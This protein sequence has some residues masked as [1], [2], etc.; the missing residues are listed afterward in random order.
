METND[1]APAL[2][3]ADGT[4]GA[5]HR[6]KAAFFDIDG[7]LLSFTTHEAP[8]STVDALHRM[9]D[10]GIKLFI[11]TGRPPI[12]VGRAIESIPIEFDGIMAM[13]GQYCWDA[14]GVFHEESIDPADVAAMVALLEREPDLACNLV[15]R[16]Y[17][18][19]SQINDTARH[20]WASLGKSV[21]DV[22]VD[23][24]ATRT[25]EHA[26]YQMSLYIPESA[27]PRYMPLFPHCKAVRWHPVFND[28]IPADGGK[29]AGMRHF[30][31][32]YGLS[33]D[34]CVAFG[35]GGNDAD[36]LAHAGVGVAMGNGT[37]SAKASADL[38][39]DDVDHDGIANACRRLGLI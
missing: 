34:E 21:P 18:Y 15:E 13:N 33:R 26:V 23:D 39:T 27:E 16:D 10:N 2:R 14:D 6:I 36:M 17:S 8:T 29:P 22:P 4:Q 24:P 37:P 31:E 32:R 19:F 30:L 35:D 1:A 20:L 28:I 3:A 7:T 5:G 11:A 25:R 9:R 38:V 12:Q